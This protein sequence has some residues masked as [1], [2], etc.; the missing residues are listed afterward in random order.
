VS[1]RYFNKTIGDYPADN[2]ALEAAGGLEGFDRDSP[3]YND[4]LAYPAGPTQFG[5]R[6]AVCSMS[7]P[8]MLHSLAR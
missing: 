5:Q 2:V 6:A 3:A 8:F 4:V 1:N 7:R